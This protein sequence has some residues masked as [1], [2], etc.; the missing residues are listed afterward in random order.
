M[1]EHDPSAWLASI[2]DIFEQLDLDLDY[3]GAWIAAWQLEDRWR[4]VAP[5]RP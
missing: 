5:D 2:V 3:L 4:S 1:S